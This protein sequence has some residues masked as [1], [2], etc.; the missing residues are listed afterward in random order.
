MLIFRFGLQQFAIPAALYLAKQIL[1]PSQTPSMSAAKGIEPQSQ[2]YLETSLAFLP[3]HQSAHFMAKWIK[4][5]LVWM[6]KLHY[7][8]PSPL[9]TQRTCYNKTVIYPGQKEGPQCVW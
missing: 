7:A 6:L 1:A 2:K 9:E 3:G 8:K 4:F 5:S